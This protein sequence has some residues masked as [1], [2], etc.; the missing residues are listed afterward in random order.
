MAKEVAQ[1]AVGA[2]GWS[3]EQVVGM[4]EQP[5]Q[6]W[7]GE[8][9][10]A[11][12]AARVLGLALALRYHPS[13]AEPYQAPRLRSCSSQGSPTKQLLLPRIQF[14]FQPCA[15]KNLDTTQCPR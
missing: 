9:T 5:A 12:P 13:P 10:F 3:L 2:A 4:Q 8:E 15:R 11:L 7:L 1:E 6:V 14:G